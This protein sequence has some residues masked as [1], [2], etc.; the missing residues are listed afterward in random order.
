M[1]CTRIVLYA[2]KTKATISVFGRGG[3]AAS[4]WNKVILLLVFSV[5]PVCVN[6]LKADKKVDKEPDKEEDWTALIKPK[7]NAAYEELGTDGEPPGTL[8][9]GISEQD[10]LKPTNAPKAP[11]FFDASIQ[12][13][14]ENLTPLILRLIKAHECLCS[15]C[16]P[17]F[18]GSFLTASQE[19]Q[20]PDSG[21]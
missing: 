5:W 8:D 10:T 16:S 14:K 18:V 15:A 1:K 20:D 4:K 21:I 2:W 3:H 17:D 7:R 11:K 19:A 6:Y 9:E 13:F 12:L